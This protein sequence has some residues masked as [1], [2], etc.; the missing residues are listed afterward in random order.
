[1]T[2]ISPPR[3]DETA[4]EGTKLARIWFRWVLDLTR[5][6]NGPPELPEYTVATLPGAAGVKRLVWVSDAGGGACPAYSDGA[7]WRR[8]TD[9]TVV[10]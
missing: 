5:R 3:A 6:V 7:D 2:Q 10:S 1:M 8:F 9:G 4:L